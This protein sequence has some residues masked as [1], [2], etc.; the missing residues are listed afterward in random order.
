MAEWTGWARWGGRSPL[1][2][3]APR[4]GA[5][6]QLRAAVRPTR[7]RPRLLRHPAFLEARGAGVGPRPFP[8]AVARNRLGGV[9]LRPRVRRGVQPMIGRKPRPNVRGSGPRPAPPDA[10]RRAEVAGLCRPHPQGRADVKPCVGL[11]GPAAPWG[12]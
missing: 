11:A 8:F 1:P 6:G 12:S 4:P 3:C 7:A 5:L 9:R 2:S 10:A